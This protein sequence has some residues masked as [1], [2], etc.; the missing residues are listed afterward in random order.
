[1]HILLDGLLVAPQEYS[2]ET[3]V[4]GDS[5]VPLISL[6]SIVAKVERDRL[7][8]RMAKEFPGYGFERHVGYATQPHREAIKE[9]GLC[10]IHRRSFCR[11]FL[12]VA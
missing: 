12:P 10:E 9:H 1:M 3:I 5:L 4:R 2:Q 6:A 11:N 7:M 8:R